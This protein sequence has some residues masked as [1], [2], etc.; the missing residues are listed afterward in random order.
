MLKKIRLVLEAIWC[1]GVMFALFVLFALGV[2][3]LQADDR[4]E[5]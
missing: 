1:F 3:D 5:C 4:V 2:N